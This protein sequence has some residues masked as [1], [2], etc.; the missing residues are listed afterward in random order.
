MTTAFHWFTI[1]SC[2][3]S[4]MAYYIVRYTS[5][6]SGSPPRNHI[7]K[8]SHEMNDPDFHWRARPDTWAGLVSTG[9]Y[10]NGLCPESFIR[11]KI[12][13]SLRLNSK[14]IFA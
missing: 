14:C 1:R 8:P 7:G 4:L 13:K 5:R 11:A 9:E 12:K 3:H 2:P 10:V 6:N